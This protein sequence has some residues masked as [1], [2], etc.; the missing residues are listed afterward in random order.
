VLRTNERKTVLNKVKYPRQHIEKSE[1]WDSSGTSKDAAFTGLHIV[2]RPIWEG[3]G[4]SKL[5]PRTG[6]EGPE[7][8]RGVA[9]LFL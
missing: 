1:N 2:D 6:H 7:G 4:E 5:P 9:L 8:G 3:K